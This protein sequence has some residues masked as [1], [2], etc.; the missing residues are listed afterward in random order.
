MLRLLSIRRLVHNTLLL[1]EDTPLLHWG[2]V[3]L[4]ERSN[5]HTAV[6]DCDVIN[7]AAMHSNIRSFWVYVYVYVNFTLFSSIYGF[8]YAGV[9]PK[10]HGNAVEKT[11]RTS[12]SVTGVVFS[13]KIWLHPLICYRW[14]FIFLLYCVTFKSNIY[15]TALPWNCET[16]QDKGD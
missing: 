9:C 14:C 10:T 7:T 4:N 1:T 16:S 11:H 5:S 15:N 6:I 12:L 13:C 3:E 2:Q 8:W